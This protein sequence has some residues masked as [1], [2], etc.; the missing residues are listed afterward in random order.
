MVGIIV[1]GR[2]WIHLSFLHLFFVQLIRGAFFLTKSNRNRVWHTG[3][4][5]KG[6]L[7]KF[8]TTP[9]ASPKAPWADDPLYTPL[10]ISGK[11]IVIQGVINKDARLKK[12]VR[13][14]FGI[15][16]P[17][18][19]WKRPNCDWLYDGGFVFSKRYTR[20]CIPE[21]GIECEK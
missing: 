8:L 4:G 21:P 14:V 10:N 7:G 1:L 9:R 6:R 3:G 2:K 18:F 13:N 12:G 5:G 16:C 15:I 19:N 11:Q 17:N 20:F